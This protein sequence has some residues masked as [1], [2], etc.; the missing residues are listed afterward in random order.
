MSAT[1]SLYRRCIRTVPAY[2]GDEAARDF[3]KLALLKEM[4]VKQQVETAESRG[5][6][7][8][9]ASPPLSPHLTRIVDEMEKD[10][11]LIEKYVTAQVKS[12]F[13]APLRDGE[14]LD[15]RLAVGDA[16]LA[17]VL[18]KVEM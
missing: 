11:A 1:L 17:D 3:F 6:S 2:I 9:S 16:Q 13:M 15:D 10:N 14:T 8:T 4:T 12:Q 5:S 18:L 7:G